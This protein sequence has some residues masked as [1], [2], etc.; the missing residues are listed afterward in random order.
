[1]W[2]G[3]REGGREGGRGKEG[4]REGGRE[5]K[6]EREGGERE[7]EGEEEEEGEGEGGERKQFIT[8][9]CTGV[10]SHLLCLSPLD[11][12]W[13]KR[14]GRRKVGRKGNASNRR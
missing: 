4:G 8:I 14:E 1:M 12:V 10:K 2:G 3:G 13:E 7:G 9:K 11:C 6:R 5:R